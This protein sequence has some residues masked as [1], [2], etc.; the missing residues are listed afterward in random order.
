M[1]FYVYQV[2][3][4][5]DPCGGDGQ[6]GQ[7]EASNDSDLPADHDESESSDSDSDDNSDNDM[8]VAQK[9]VNWCVGTLLL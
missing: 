9:K 3:S 4:V 2:R 5:L 8:D 6:E 1:C 7:D